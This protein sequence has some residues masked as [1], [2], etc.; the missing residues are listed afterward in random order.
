MTLL[1]RYCTEDHWILINSRN[2]NF[3]PTWFHPSPLTQPLTSTFL[4]VTVSL[5]LFYMSRLSL[6]KLLVLPV[7]ISQSIIP[8]WFIHI[9][10][11]CRISCFL[12][13]PSSIK[14]EQIKKPRSRESSMCLLLQVGGS[15]FEHIAKKRSFPSLE[16]YVWLLGKDN[17][18]QDS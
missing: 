16:S 14:L 12:A 17:L 4:S 9:I 15:K 3:I 10:I 13:Q 8:S 11:N 18:E 1:I 7:L 2:G 5:R 6:I